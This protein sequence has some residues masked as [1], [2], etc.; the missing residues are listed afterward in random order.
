MDRQLIR[1]A[2][3]RS[4]SRSISA[5]RFSRRILGKE[6]R[7]H[8][9]T[10]TSTRRNVS[11]RPSGEPT[12]ERRAHSHHRPL[13]DKHLASILI[14]TKL[15]G[16]LLFRF[17]PAGPRE[18]R[19]CIDCRGGSLKDGKSTY[20]C[21]TPRGTASLTRIGHD[22]NDAAPKWLANSLWYRILHKRWPLESIPQP[23]L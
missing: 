4:L 3:L 8:V 17:I 21:L 22:R 19:F 2:L 15:I 20:E 13:R 12:N 16:R 5:Q 18:T 14:T 11:G 1:A 10:Q 9:L 23:Q 6:Q 7:H